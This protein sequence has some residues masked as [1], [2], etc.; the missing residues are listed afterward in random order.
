MK[1]WKILKIYKLQA[2]TK[3]EAQRVFGEAVQAGTDTEH[4]EMVIVK[5]EEPRGFFSAVKKQLAS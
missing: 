1:T 5:E 3:T 2:E 4:L